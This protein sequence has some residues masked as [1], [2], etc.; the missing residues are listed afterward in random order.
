MS[1][2]ELRN[3]KLE[4]TLELDITK[5]PEVWT[6]PTPPIAAKF[7]VIVQLLNST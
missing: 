4:V 6:T 2:I 1:T 7:C 3:A 5:K